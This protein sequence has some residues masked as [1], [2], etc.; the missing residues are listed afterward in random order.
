LYKAFLVDDE[1]FIKARLRGLID[2]KKIGF[3]IVGDASDGEDAYKAIL[4]L[5]PDLVLTDI[6]MPV[7]SG[8]EL[9]KRVIPV[10]PECRFIIFSGYSDFEYAHEAIRYGVKS[11]LLKP[12]GETDLANAV[13]NVKNE[14]EAERER[15][16]IL[17]HTVTALKEKW[18]RDVLFGRNTASIASRAA[19]LNIEVEKYSFMVLIIDVEEPNTPDAEDDENRQSRKNAIIGE[20][21]GKVLGEYGTCIIVRD[22]QERYVLLLLIPEDFQR[23]CEPAGIAENLKEE[24]VQ[25]VRGHITVGYSDVVEE[26]PHVAGC[27]KRSKMAIESKFV[28]GR[29]RIIGFNKIVGSTDSDSLAKIADW[30]K[31]ALEEAVLHIN[32]DAVRA[33]TDKLFSVLRSLAKDPALIRGIITE[34]MAGL[35]GILTKQNGDAGQVLGDH[36][37]LDEWFERHTLDELEKEFRDFCIKI[38]DY[39]AKVYASRRAG[40]ADQIAAYVKQHYS[41][42]I[43]MKSIAQKFYMNPVYLGQL[44]KND[45]GLLFNHYLT[46]VRM[47]AARKMLVESDLSIYDIAERAGYKTLRNFYVAFKK[48]FNC[49]PTEYRNGLLHSGG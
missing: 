4:A 38:T 21:A 30:N 46:E 22:E 13:E 47:E 23:A 41:E 43:S 40:I 24:L 18:A 29:D 35:L 16:H 45:T 14:I 39:M 11:Y 37:V 5:K 1:P 17:L 7:F 15:E 32:Y 27:Y 36:F 49:T 34:C 2:W 28:L 9:I 33:E 10:L 42:D 6:R 12:I 25:F 44:F 48:S 26:L 19:E 31:T 20:T 3:Q 8:L